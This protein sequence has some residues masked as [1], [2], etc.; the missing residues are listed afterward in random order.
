[1]WS[2][3]RK[4]LV[5]NKE[6][7]FSCYIRGQ[8]MTNALG[9]KPG[10]PDVFKTYIASK[11][12][13]APTMEQEIMATSVEEVQEKGI[14]VF[15]NGLFFRTSDGEFFDFLDV[16]VMDNIGKLD[17]YTYKK[18][19][20]MTQYVDRG[21]SVFKNEEG[22][23]IPFYMNP[24]DP[25]D[26][27][28]LVEGEYV[29]VPFI[30]DYQWK[31]GMKEAISIM[32]KMDAGKAAARKAKAAAKEKTEEASEAS[33]EAPKKRGR[34]PKKLAESIDNTQVNTPVDIND[35]MNHYDGLCLGAGYNFDA[36]KITNYKKVIDGGWQFSRRTPIDVPDAYIDDKGEPH[37]TYIIDPNT[38]MKRLNLFTRP[39]RAD[40]AQGPRVA[41]ASSEM[42]PAGSEFYFKVTL[43]NPEHKK[44]FFECMDLKGEIGMCQW[45]SGGFGKIRWTL[46]DEHG[47][48]IDVDPLDLI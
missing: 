46:A 3:E 22:N 2:N 11:A 37:S 1:M 39:L 28:N 4:S 8:F 5:S 19:W 42:V 21:I 45:R 40:T 12:P 30:W 34:K 9:T 27:S 26:T 18:H 6:G 47:K 13:D 32:S 48:P 7:S 24:D 25:D 33:E 43:M 41:L 17:S 35:V 29:C 10:D 36:A 44:A 23:F 20:I 31:G 16:I 14:T 15:P 38:G